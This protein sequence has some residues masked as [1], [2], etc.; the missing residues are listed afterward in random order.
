M[1]KCLCHLHL[2]KTSSQSSF[3]EKD[4]KYWRIH[5][6]DDQN[7]WLKSSDTNKKDSIVYV[8]NVV[9]QRKDTEI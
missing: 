7:I 9:G 1:R 5:K 3:K 6:P 2:S 4:K 8:E